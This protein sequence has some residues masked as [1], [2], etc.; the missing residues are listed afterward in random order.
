VNTINAGFNNPAAHIDA[1]RNFR[2]A[3]KQLW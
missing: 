3:T 1:I 2:E